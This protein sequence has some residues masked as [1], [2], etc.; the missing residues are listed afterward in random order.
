MIVGWISRNHLAS[1][2]GRI[3]FLTSLLIELTDLNSGH[4]QLVHSLPTR[5][6][7][8]SR[9]GTL[10][11]CSNHENCILGPFTVLGDVLFFWEELGMAI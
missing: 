3:F 9:T 10:L 1:G 6:L 8:I 5:R 4:S 7:R 2:R 11:A